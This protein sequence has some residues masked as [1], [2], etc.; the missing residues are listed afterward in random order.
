MRI[1][2][3][4][5][6]LAA[7]AAL[8]CAAVA[9]CSS[10]ST[11]SPTGTSG[12]TT[13]SSASGTST[14]TGTSSTSLTPV[15]SPQGTQKWTNIYG[16]VT[17]T[18]AANKSAGGA[19]KAKAAGIYTAQLLGLFVN[20]D[21]MNC[22]YKTA[23]KTLRPVDFSYMNEDLTT[24]AI[25][26]IKSAIPKLTP[27]SAETDALRMLTLSCMNSDQFSM[28][29]PGFQ[30]PFT[31]SI[32]VDAGPN[33]GTVETLKVHIFWYLNLQ[34]DDTKSKAKVLSSITRDAVYTIVPGASAQHP[35]LIHAWSGRYNIWGT[36]PDSNPG[37]RDTP[38]FPTAPQYTQ[39]MQSRSAAPTS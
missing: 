25:D 14:P 15:T 19:D 21:L 10:T 28:R 37:N 4:G 17:T 26:S 3:R 33:I 24:G 22:D 31:T 1:T 29:F 11:A 35:W 16:T 13:S 20:W 36:Q 8:L 23:S 5:N 39:Y 32:S 18:D 34:Y 2:K 12:T 9:G 27:T 6:A 7:T 38:V 30:K